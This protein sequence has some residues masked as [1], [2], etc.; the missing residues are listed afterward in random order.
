MF[1]QKPKI[2][3]SAAALAAALSISAASGQEG[4]TREGEASANAAAAA[5]ANVSLVCRGVSLSVVESDN[6]AASTNSTTFAT[7]P[8]ATASVTV[9]GPR[10]LKVTFTAETRC[11][12]SGA[13]D[14]CDLRALVNGVRMHPQDDIRTIDSESRFPQG[15]AYEWFV[16]VAQAGTYTV[17]IQGRVFSSATVF[18]VD[19]WTLDY[20]VTTR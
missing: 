7:L 2:A 8:N 4:W 17:A 6:V 16:A 18:T 15:H 13:S 9:N 12:Q 3:A 1:S 10:C 11:G 19:D 5:R 20:E 14:R